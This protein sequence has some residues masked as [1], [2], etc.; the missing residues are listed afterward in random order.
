MLPCLA[1]DG[2][3]AQ[4]GSEERLDGFARR[5]R[6]EAKPVEGGADRDGTEIALATPAAAAKRAPGGGR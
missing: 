1:A 2:R 6:R 3:S 5:Y 4:W